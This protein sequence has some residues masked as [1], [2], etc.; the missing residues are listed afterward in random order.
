MD[1]RTDAECERSG[2]MS[3]NAPLDIVKSVQ[4]TNQVEFKTTL[5]DFTIEVYPDN[6]PKT[7][8]NFLQ[9]VKSGHY[10]G[11]IFHRVI[12]NFMV[13]GGGFTSDMIHKDTRA[14][15]PLEAPTG[16]TS[17]GWRGTN[18]MH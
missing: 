10:N 11:T 13:Q 18:G 3:T 1:D 8:Q 4:A 5:G 7:V 9:Y 14:P 16:L 15:I 17:T 12:G 6:A 2:C